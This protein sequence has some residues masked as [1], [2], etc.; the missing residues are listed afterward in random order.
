MPSGSR[1][2][3]CAGAR[4]GT[5]SAGAAT[6]LR[7]TR[8]RAAAASA[9]PRS[10]GP[11][12]RLGRPRP[13]TACDTDRSTAA[14]RRFATRSPAIRASRAHRH[15]TRRRRGRAPPPARRRILPRRRARKTRPTASRRSQLPRRQRACVGRIGRSC[16][17]LHRVF[18]DWKS[19]MAV[20]FN[21]SSTMN[22]DCAGRRWPSPIRARHG[23]RKS[24]FAPTARSVPVCARECQ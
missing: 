22:R 5:P 3:E 21:G 13:G 8:G 4:S 12:R 9:S 14:P 23:G 17:L 15:T 2:A 24:S 16:G 19:A 11:H 7:S 20:R 18:V 1:R 6:A 10:N